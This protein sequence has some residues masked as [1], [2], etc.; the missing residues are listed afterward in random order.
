MFTEEVIMSEKIKIAQNG[1]AG[2]LKLYQQNY[3]VYY[4]VPEVKNG[5][6]LCGKICL[7][8]LAPSSSGEMATKSYYMNDPDNV[9]VLILDLFKGL[10]RFEKERNNLS[11]SK[12]YWY[13]H[14]FDLA[15][16]DIGIKT[17]KGERV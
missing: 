14:V 13:R 3:Y 11:M 12:V 9:K 7:E 17:L 2:N 5:E 4:L 16:K 15:I 1:S 8:L 6:E 10:M